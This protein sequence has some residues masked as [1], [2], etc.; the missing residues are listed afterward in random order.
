MVEN[1][2]PPHIKTYIRYGGN[3][4]DWALVTS[5][6]LSKQ[7]W[8]EAANNAGEMRIS[9]YEIGV[10]IWPSLL[11]EDAKMVPTFL[12]DKPDADSLGAARTVVGLRIPYNLPLQPYGRG[13]IPWVA[14]ASYDEPDWMGRTWERG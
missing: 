10:L 13:E 11:E 14:T 2:L 5:A 7:A 12:T 1:E 9:S 4:I 6:N 3:C 8:G